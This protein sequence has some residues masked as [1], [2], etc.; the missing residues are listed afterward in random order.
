VCFLV[1]LYCQRNGIWALMLLRALKIDV[2]AALR[3]QQGVAQKQAVVGCNCAL[4]Q[5]VFCCV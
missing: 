1:E 5:H 4:T 3:L 2:A